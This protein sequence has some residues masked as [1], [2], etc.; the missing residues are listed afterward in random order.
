LFR[1]IIASTAYESSGGG[2][3]EVNAVLSHAGQL[4]AGGFDGD[5][6]ELSGGSVRSDSSLCDSSLM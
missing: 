4:G 6:D 1:H 5:W 2:V 3:F